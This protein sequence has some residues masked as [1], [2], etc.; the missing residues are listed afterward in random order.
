MKHA[1]NKTDVV[2]QFHL[3]LIFFLKKAIIS[4]HHRFNLMEI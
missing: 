2:K 3:M 1:Q 4:L